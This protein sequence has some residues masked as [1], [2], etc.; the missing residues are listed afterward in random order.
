MK[1]FWFGLLIIVTLFIRYFYFLGCGIEMLLPHKLSDDYVI[2]N[3]EK[4]HLKMGYYC[5]NQQAEVLSLGSGG[6][7]ITLSEEDK[8]VIDRVYVSFGV[9]FLV[10]RVIDCNIQLNMAEPELLDEYLANY[11][12]DVDYRYFVGDTTVQLGENLK[13]YYHRGVL[14]LIL[15]GI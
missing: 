4:I 6:Y 5:L 13:L 15:S 2:I 14:R 10:S 7:Q 3:K 1:Q 11:Q 9:D 8:N 12:V